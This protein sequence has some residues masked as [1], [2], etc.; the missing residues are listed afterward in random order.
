MPSESDHLL[1]FPSDGF[2]VFFFSGYGH[3]SPSTASGRLFCIFYALIGI[4]L[5]GVFLTGLGQNL[6]KPL[7]IFRNKSQNKC[8]KILK[9]VVIGI[10]GFAILI[11]LPALGFHRLEDWSMF[12][13][14]YYAVITLT[15]VG[16]GDYVAGMCSL[17]FYF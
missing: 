4:P 13:G 2:K 8:I 7:T 5:T 12:E 3:I 15:T 14:I 11:F 9:T 17:H 16:F 10:L 6:S 1:T